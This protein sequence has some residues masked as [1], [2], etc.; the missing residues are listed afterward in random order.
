MVVDFK[1]GVGSIT[2]ANLEN[3]NDEDMINALTLAVATIAIAHSKPMTDDEKWK[4]H[5][6]LLNLL[7]QKYLAAVEKF[8]DGIEVVQNGKQ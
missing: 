4:V 6:D 3:I 7:T 8:W 5:N 2:F 1:N